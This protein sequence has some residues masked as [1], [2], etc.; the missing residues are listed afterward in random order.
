MYATNAELV[1]YAAERGSVISLDEASALVARASTYIDVAY[2]FVGNPVTDEA[3]FPRTD[4]GITAYDGVIPAPVRRATL[5]VAYDF[6]LGINVEFG[7]DR[8]AVTRERVSQGAIE[9]YYSV[10]QDDY[11]STPMAVHRPSQKILQDAGL[12][13][14]FGDMY[15]NVV[16]A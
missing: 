10:K 4:T 1:T 6:Q 2:K 3:S 11:G 12:I 15:I 13:D 16:R 5:M 14:G 8:S 7:G 9:T